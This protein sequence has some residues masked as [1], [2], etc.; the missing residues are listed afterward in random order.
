MSV[1]LGIV[2][3]LIDLLI[4]AIFIAKGASIWDF[5]CSE[6]YV[7]LVL[8]FF[9]VWVALVT[10]PVLIYNIVVFNITSAIFCIVLGLLAFA[11][12]YNLSRKLGY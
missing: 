10:V 8:V 4:T 12:A 9:L 1:L 7:S 2:T 11:G 5:C 3:L 6:G